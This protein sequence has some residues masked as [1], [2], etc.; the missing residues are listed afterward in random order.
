M[1]D[2]EEKCPVLYK[3]V[4][5]DVLISAHKL[6]QPPWRTKDPFLFCVYHNDAYPKGNASMGP[7][8]NE[9]R[10]RSIGQ[11]FSGKDGWSMYHGETVPGFPKHPH[12]GFETITIT[13]KGLCDH[14]DSLGCAGRFGFGDCQWMTAGKGISHS[15]MFPLV[16]NEA[17]NP[18]ELFQIWINL[19]RQDKMADPYFKM[20]WADEIP[21]LK[22]CDDNG[23]ITSVTYYAGRFEDAVPPAPPPRSWAARV[24]TDV[25][26]W[27]IRMEPGAT[28]T[29]PAC[30]EEDA[31]ATVNR[32]LYLFHPK[33]AIHVA[34]G[35]AK[36]T[37]PAMLEIKPDMPAEL[38]NCGEEE[39]E[40]LFLQVR[41]AGGR[42]RHRIRL[43]RGSGCWTML[44]LRN[45]L[46]S[47][48]KI[49]KRRHL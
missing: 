45:S 48:H 15:E 24:D 32:S 28:W 9:L 5:P 49:L 39:C 33:N 10:G 11:D 26:V 21:T 3:K 2:E 6:A 47:L 44:V 17:E 35:N 7:V 46:F 12:R 19:P 1:A 36:I 41:S 4:D 31:D 14:S 25:C 38:Q 18:L 29:L 34:V 8:R 37:N 22:F 16:N 27:T 30:A 42:I 40:M 13:R 43:V 20:L 23:K